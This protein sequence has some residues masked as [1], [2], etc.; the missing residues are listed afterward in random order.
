MI[1]D[2]FL[3]SFNH[4]NKT[5]VFLIENKSKYCFIQN[6]GGIS[7]LYHLA[8]PNDSIYSS[9]DGKNLVLKKGGGEFIYAI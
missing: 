8:Q 3:D 4:S 5:L 9:N 7:S 6:Q 2:K 1:A